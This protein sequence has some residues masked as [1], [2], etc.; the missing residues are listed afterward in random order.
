MRFFFRTNFR[1]HSGQGLATGSSQV[2]YLHFG[3]RL[4]PK[5]YFPRRVFRRTR[6]PPQ[7]SGQAIPVSTLSFWMYLQFGIVGT[8]DE[9]AEAAEL[10]DEGRAALGAFLVEGLRLLLD[11]ALLV[12]ALRVAGAGLEP[13]EATRLDDHVLAALGALLVDRDP[14]PL[15]VLG[16]ASRLQDLFEDGVILPEALEPG[17]LAVADLVELLLHLG[18]EGHVQEVGEVLDQELRDEHAQIRRDELAFVPGRHRPCPGA[19]R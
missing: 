7:S 8:G 17:P 10:D 14:G 16:L 11:Q 1:P 2:A 19:S 15:E 9:R 4:Q 13:A 5:K 3:K 12:G 6:V 18:R